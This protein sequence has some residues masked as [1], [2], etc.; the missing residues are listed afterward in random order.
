MKEKQITQKEMAKR[1]GISERTFNTKINKGCFNSNELSILIEVLGIEN[2][3]PIF[4]GKE[5]MV[6]S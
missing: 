6:E 3:M 1:M 4:F 2:P 5:A